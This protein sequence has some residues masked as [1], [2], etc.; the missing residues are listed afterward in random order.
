MRIFSVT[1]IHVGPEELRRR[2][3]RYDALLPTGVTLDLADIGPA[4]PRALDTADEIGASTD[5]VVA[6]LRTAPAGYDVLLPDCVLDP[7]VAEL[8]GE[9]PVVGILQ[10]SLGWQVIRGRR[11][12]MVARNEAIAAELSD[13][14]S[15]YGWGQHVA[16]VEV[17]GLE[18]DAIADHAR[19]DAA[20]DSALGRFDSSVDVVINGCS[21]VPVTSHHPLAVVDPTSLAL[22][23]V[24]AGDAR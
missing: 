7:G 16:G 13:R 1:P 12:G 5:A 20:L 19:W 3:A 18:V 4:A 21:A 23:L 14:A 15:A 17:L 24:A 2:Q 9:L 11:S 8:R 22:R 10:L 6:A